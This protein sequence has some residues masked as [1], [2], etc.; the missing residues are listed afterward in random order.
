MV[1]FAGYEMPVQYFGIMNEH[2]WCRENASMFDV[3]H[4]GQVKI[5]GKDRFDFIESL[6][7]GDIK[8]LKEGSATLSLLTTPNGGIYDDLIVTNLDKYL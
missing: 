5:H 1:P 4:M 2:N 3:G 6:C 8:E 7:V